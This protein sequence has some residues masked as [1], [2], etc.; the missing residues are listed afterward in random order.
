MRLVRAG[1]VDAQHHDD[2]LGA[3][4]IRPDS[5]STLLRYWHTTLG[6]IDADYTFGDLVSLLRGVHDI[7]VLSPLLE[8]DVLAFLAEADSPPPEQD[9]APLEFVQVHNIADLQRYE[10]D[11]LQPDKNL[12]W[13][14]DDEAEEH[15]QISAGLAALT[16]EPQPLKIIDAT[17]DDPITSQPLLRRL[18]TPVIHGRW[19]PPYRLHRDFS[20]YGKWP[21]PYDGYFTAH[22]D[23]DPQ[24]YAGALALD[25]TPVS[26]L[27]H[28]TLKYD[29]AVVFRT[30]Q[31]DA[32]AVVFDTQITITFGEFLH[33]IF[34]ELGFFGSPAE[35]DATLHDVE[36][37]AAA[38]RPSDDA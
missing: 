8:C 32:D 26:Q 37:R 15:D 7:D 21:E 4:P 12:N 36:E 16:G 33:A 38:V 9:H 28:L 14:D 19:T 5:A 3:V 22:P 13:M 20:G 35:R 11:P 25:F 17:A 2:E 24:H 27:L 30:Q 23:I 31:P 1:I 10:P 29:P 18:R 34:W 6:D